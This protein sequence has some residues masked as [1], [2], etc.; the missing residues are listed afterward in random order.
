MSI[1]LVSVPFS[2]N[3]RSRKSYYAGRFLFEN[4]FVENYIEALYSNKKYAKLVR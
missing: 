3:R 4:D 1:I 2:C